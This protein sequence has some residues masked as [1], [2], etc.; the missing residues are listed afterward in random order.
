MATSRFENRIFIDNNHPQYEE[1]RLAR[2]VRTIVHYNTPELKYPTVSEVTELERITRRWAVGDMLY[3]YA[4]EYY[5]NPK[6][7]WVLAWYNQKP[8]DSHFNFGDKIYIP[9]P[10]EKVLFV[11]GL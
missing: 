1:Y 2:N 8:T 5:G 9:L 10:L 7:W 11:L 4:A 3:K 6:L